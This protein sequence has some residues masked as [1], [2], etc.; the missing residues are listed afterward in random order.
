MSSLR[1]TCYVAIVLSLV[2]ALAIVSGCGSSKPVIKSLAP[3][4][5]LAGTRFKIS[6]SGFGKTQGKSVVHFGALTAAASS[7][8]D[9]SIT[10]L[11]PKTSSSGAAAISVTTTVATSNKVTFTVNKGFTSSTPLP[12]MLNYLKTKGIDT[13]GWSFSVVSTSK[14]DPNFKIDKGS[15][16]GEASQYFLVFKNSDGWAVIDYGT[17]FT[18]SQLKADGAPGDLPPTQTSPTTTPKSSSST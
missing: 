15:K 9:T 10:V 16:S 14:T 7:W 17:G 18:A 5:G 3:K 12:A 4:D 13:A 6:G 8:S 1:K 2:A 11:V